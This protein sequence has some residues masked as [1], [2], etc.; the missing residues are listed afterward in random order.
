MESSFAGLQSALAQH[1]AQLE[2]ES[3]RENATLTV[4]CGCA[5]TLGCA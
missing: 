1:L 4:R 5:L 3:A 2:R